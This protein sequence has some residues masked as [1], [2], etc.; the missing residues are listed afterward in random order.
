MN[1]LSQT[2]RAMGLVIITLPVIMVGC[3]GEPVPAVTVGVDGCASCGMLIDRVNQAAG[4]IDHGEFVP[5]C[6]PGCLLNEHDARRK[7]ASPPP[8]TALFADY[9]SEEFS[10]AAETAFLLTDHLPT[11]MN[12]RVICFGSLAAAEGMRQHDDEVVTDWTGYRVQRGEPDAVLETVFGP[13]GMEPDIVEV[14]KGDIVLWRSSGQEL[15][16]DLDWTIR[17]YPEVVPPVVAPSG[18]TV[19]LRFMATR[20]GAGFPIER[21]SGGGPLGMLKVSGAHTMDEAAQ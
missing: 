4:W 3:G 21:R 14:N 2:M 20:P 16:E 17:G 11:V 15:I 12:G 8:Q 5:F 13:E 9:N 1:G 19:E 10:S 7:S 6:S 18:E